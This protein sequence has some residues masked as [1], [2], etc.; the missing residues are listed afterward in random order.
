[1]QAALELM[2][3]G[4]LPVERLTT[5]RFP[6]ERAAEAYQLI[7]SQREPSLGI[8]LQYPPA[9]PP[10]RRRIQ[11]RS[12][13]PTG[14]KLG[15]SFVGAGNFARVVLLPLIS[16]EARIDLRGVCTAKGLNADHSA[17]KH[18]FAF[19]TTDANEIWAD[20]DTQAV[21][22]ATRHDLH[23]ELVI[24]ALRAGKHVFVEKPLCITFDQLARIEECVTDLGK[25]CPMIMVGFN[26]R[27]SPTLTQLRRFFSAASPLSL[28]YRFASGPLAADHWT[29]NEEIGGGRI[30]GEACHA[31][32][33]C[34]ALTGSLPTRVYAESVDRAGAQQTTDDRVFITIRHANGSVSSISYQ[35]AGDPGFPKERIEV[36]GTGRSAV[37]ENWDSLTLW[38]GGRKTNARGGKDK[39]HRSELR[40]FL[41]ACRGASDWPIP[42]DELYG[43]AEASLLAVKSLREGMP[44]ICGQAAPLR[45]A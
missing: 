37:S 24:S 45:E 28:S 3:A 33:T 40:E 11:L 29:Q 14:E 1:M 31:I 39:G 34:V 42:W 36:L 22:I 21:F 4:K 7:T 17:R 16:A 6:I 41:K 20:R 19:A 23:A 25:S 43:V 15:I 8:L 5:H 38:S 32:D 10:R 9:S 27:F 18:E 26:R 44:Q 2:A 12:A 35:A 13:S 30:I